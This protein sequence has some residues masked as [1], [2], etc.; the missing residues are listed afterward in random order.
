MNSHQTSPSCS[1]SCC[2]HRYAWIATRIIEKGSGERS[3]LTLWEAYPPR[4]LDEK[5]KDEI[6]ELTTNETGSQKLGKGIIFGK[7]YFYKI[8]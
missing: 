2:F 7:I 8:G 6:L 4:L 1:C 5:K 3:M